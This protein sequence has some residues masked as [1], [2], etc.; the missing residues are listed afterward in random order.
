MEHPIY[1][2]LLFGPPGAGKSTQAEYLMQHWNLAAIST[3]KL[4]REQIAAGTPIGLRVREVLA[5]GELVDDALMIE[6]L[7][8]SP[9]FRR[10]TVSCST[11][12]RARFRKRKRWTKF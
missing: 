9:R 11:A 3:G 4:L 2:A 10:T 12:F 7:R 1:H 5:R 8:G 6:I